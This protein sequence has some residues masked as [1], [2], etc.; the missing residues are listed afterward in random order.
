MAD[1]FIENQINI[2]VAAD[3]HNTKNVAMSPEMNLPDDGLIRIVLT[4]GEEPGDLDSHLT[5]PTVG[6][7]SRYEVFF[8]DKIY[9]HNGV[10]ADLD[11]DDITSYGPETITIHKNTSG[12][13]DNL[14]YFVHDY[15]NRYANGS[16]EM[17]LSNAQVRVYKGKKLL[18]TF[19]VP[20]DEIGIY[21]HV[22]DIDKDNN[23]IPVNTMSNEKPNE[24]IVGGADTFEQEDVPDDTDDTYTDTTVDKP[25]GNDDTTED[26]IAEDKVT[27]K[28]A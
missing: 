19:V 27:K 24:D 10:I 12:T 14:H 9:E 2:V 22:F 4:W 26:V 8:D 5:G 6:G 13:K 20:T 18:N 15:S 21:W 3:E 28:A 11:L 17:S 7:K 16:N 23:I 25:T 1:G